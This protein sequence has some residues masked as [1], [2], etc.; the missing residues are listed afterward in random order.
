MHAC[1]FQVQDFFKSGPGLSTDCFRSISAQAPIK[2]C[3]PPTC[4]LPACRVQNHNYI[5][6]SQLTKLLQK[7][8]HRL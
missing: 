1:V 7:K 5:A 4:K 2:I 8:L 6:D 3:K